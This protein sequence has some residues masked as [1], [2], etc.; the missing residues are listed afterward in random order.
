MLNLNSLHLYLLFY[1][2]RLLNIFRLTII[3][4]NICSEFDVMHSYINEENK[5]QVKRK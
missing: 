1:D 4:E 3:I 5:F 2:F